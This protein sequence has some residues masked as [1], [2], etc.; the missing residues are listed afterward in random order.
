VFLA[1]AGI[2]GPSNGGALAHAT[3]TRGAPRGM[4]CGRVTGR[5]QACG[6]DTT[7]TLTTPGAGAVFICADHAEQAVRAGAVDLD[8]R[9]T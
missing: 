8:T 5:D 3:V 1:A 2:A 4:P 7:H 6:E 9:P